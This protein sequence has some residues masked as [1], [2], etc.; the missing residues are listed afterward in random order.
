MSDDTLEALYQAAKQLY[1]QQHYH[2]ATALFGILSFFNAKQPIFWIG[3]GSCEYFCHHYEAALFAY[4]MAMHANPNDPAPHLYSCRCFEELKQIDNA[5]N[6]LNLALF[7]IKGDES[8]N[9]LRKQIEE[10]KR[11][12]QS[13]K[14]G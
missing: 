10:E 11:D 12:L 8:K 9:E 7:L 14:K 3:L 4:G 6:A 5:L 2:E 1:E 13:H